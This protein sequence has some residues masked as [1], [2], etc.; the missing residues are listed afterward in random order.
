MYTPLSKEEKESNV[1]MLY[2]GDVI[3]KEIEAK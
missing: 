2:V 3:R 1:Y